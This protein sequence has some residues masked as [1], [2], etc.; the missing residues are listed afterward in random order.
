MLGLLAGGRGPIPAPSAIAG[1]VT[2][3]GSLER[4]VEFHEQAILELERQ[5][6]VV[7]M[8]ETRVEDTQRVV[9]ELDKKLD[10]SMWGA[11]TLSD[12]MEETQ[13]E[14]AE[15]G[16][17]LEKSVRDAKKLSDFAEIRHQ[18][19]A[20]LDKKMYE[21]LQDMELQLTRRVTNLEQWGDDMAMSL[22][23]VK[24]R[25]EYLGRGW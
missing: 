4:S 24:D 25:V 20:D 9:A 15:L 16:K 11:K 2:R 12:L 21:S 6:N 8:L 17:K 23:A 1:V 22:S 14:V 13:L 5:A 7:D 10:K 18:V 19:M 3:V